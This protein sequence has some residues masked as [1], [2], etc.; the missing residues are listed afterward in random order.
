M[1]HIMVDL[2]LKSDKQ[3]AENATTVSQNE[4]NSANLNHSQVTHITG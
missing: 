4:T 3:N 1:L 2:I